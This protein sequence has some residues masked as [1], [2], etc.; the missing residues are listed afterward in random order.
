MIKGETRSYDDEMECKILSVYHQHIRQDNQT[1]DI[2]V[3]WNGILVRIY[4]VAL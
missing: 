4:D 3:L 2:I 1:A